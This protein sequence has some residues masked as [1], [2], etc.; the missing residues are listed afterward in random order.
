[1]SHAHLSR[2]FRSYH[3]SSRFSYQVFKSKTETE[4]GKFWH[5]KC[6]IIINIAIIFIYNFPLETNQKVCS[7]KKSLSNHLWLSDIL[8]N[9]ESTLL[10]LLT[11]LFLSLDLVSLFFFTF[12]SF[13]CPF[14]ISLDLIN[15]ASI[16]YFPSCTFL[17]DIPALNWRV[18]TCRM[19]ML[20]DVGWTRLWEKREKQWVGQL[21][22]EVVGPHPAVCMRMRHAQEVGASS[23]LER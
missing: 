6:N 19:M 13:F 7:I 14:H 3:Q 8:V 21:P 5:V 18:C 4:K 16:N 17:E 11:S 1:M 10:S 2:Y 22:P 12:T 15:K 20:M 23:S 9:K